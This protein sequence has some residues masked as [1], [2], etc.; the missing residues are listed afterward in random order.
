MN[1]WASFQRS[2]KNYCVDTCRRIGLASHHRFRRTSMRHRVLME[3]IVQS[4]LEHR[5]LA[6]GGFPYFSRTAVLTWTGI[7]CA[8]VNVMGWQGMSWTVFRVPYIDLGVQ[9]FNTRK[10]KNDRHVLLAAILRYFAAII[11]PVVCV[12]Q[13]IMRLKT[14]NANVTK[15]CHIPYSKVLK[16]GG[17]TSCQRLFMFFTWHLA[18]LECTG[19]LI[20]RRRFDETLVRALSGNAWDLR[21]NA[22]IY[23]L[24]L[25]CFP[26]AHGRAGDIKALFVHEALRT[27][28]KKK[29]AIIGNWMGLAGDA[30]RW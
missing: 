5:C 28:K 6:G 16:C 7:A 10:S 22:P 26:F 23:L 25:D 2:Q 17:P 15:P 18:W 8:C 29:L 9:A 1:S 3:K 14:N 27:R 19:S 11:S 20:C 24:P 30:N 21:Q 13:I 4:Y 12:V